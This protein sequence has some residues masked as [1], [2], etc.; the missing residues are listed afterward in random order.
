VA[1]EQIRKVPY[2]VCRM[3]QEERVEQ[4][5]TQVSRMVPYEETVRIP[6]VVEKRIPVTCNYTVPHVECYRVPV[7][8][9]CSVPSC[10]VPAISSCDAAVGSG[11]AM[12]LPGTNG[13]TFASPAAPTPAPMTSSPSNHEKASE[14]PAKDS[15]TLGGIP[16]YHPST[17]NGGAA[18][19]PLTAPMVPVIPAPP[20]GK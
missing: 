5:P 16:G 1:E 12:T 20:A 14:S 19:G 18:S 6:H 15:H 8:D 4:V 9:G 13:K 10:D 2:E 3:V 7:D 17:E 11:P